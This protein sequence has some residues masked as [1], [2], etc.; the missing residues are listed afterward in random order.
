MNDT[1]DFKIIKTGH[2]HRLT[3]FYTTSLEAANHIILTQQF[4]LEKGIF[5]D[6]VYFSLRP[7]IINYGRG[8]V[9]KRTVLVADVYI[10]DYIVIPQ[11]I[12]KKMIIKSSE[13]KKENINTIISSF[14]NQKVIVCLDE[15]RI[16]NIKYCIGEKP[17]VTCLI[18]PERRSLFYT[19]SKNEA[20]EICNKQCF[21]KS[22]CPFGKGIV[23]YDNLANAFDNC[24]K[25]N[26][27]LACDAYVKNSYELKNNETLNSIDLDIKKKFRVFIGKKHDCKYYIF[28][29]NRLISAIHFCGGE[30]W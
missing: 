17:Q 2:I 1:P 25:K 12:A 23:L 27:F 15:S 26:I 18:N 20:K 5:G 21:I 28:T 13:I 4:K 16:K 19:C 10:G 22:D 8:S 30:D 6:G 3:L 7:Y 29:D 24:K 11:K 9:K 14:I